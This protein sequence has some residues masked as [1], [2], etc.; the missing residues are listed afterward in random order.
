M[1]DTKIFSDC[2]QNAITIFERTKSFPKH[3]RPNLGRK[4][5]ESCLELLLNVRRA[6]LSKRCR[7]KYLSEASDNLDDLRVL[8]MLC[9]DIDALK[10]NSFSEI[11]ERISEIGKELGGLIKYEVAN[12]NR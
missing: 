11:T 6:N 2:Y 7:I 10:I 5:E 3:L 4:L 9:R 1:N 12:A 8:T